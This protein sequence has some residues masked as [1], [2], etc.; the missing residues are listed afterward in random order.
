T[1]HCDLD[2]PTFVGN[3]LTGLYQRTYG[4]QAMR[5]AE[6]L[7]VTT[8]T[9]AATSRAI[10]RYNPVVIPNPVDAQRFRPDVDG[11]A[12]RGRWDLAPDER[13]V[14]LVG[15]VVPHKGIEHLVEAARSLDHARVVIVGD[16]PFLPEV[17]R[18]AATF[19]VG[20]RIVFQ[21]KVPFHDLP[22]YYA[23]CDVFAL[24]SV[25]RLEAF[26]IVAL[27]AMATAKPVVV[28]DIPG[29]REVVTN[30]VEGLLAEPVNPPD[31]AAKINALLADLALRVAMGARG[32][33]KVESQFGIA[34]ITDAV[35]AVY[36][37]VRGRRN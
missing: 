32:R 21:G 18:L 3:V 28:T 12:I 7:I 25:S 5:R 4:R 35:E 15:R 22:A 6:K 33:K 27:E 34:R 8:E 31:L 30:G 1:Y 13:A 16:G 23:A 24:P 9:Y 29:V 11:S 19:G 14:L 37:E 36:R 17:R 26:G 20:D 10:W 2:I